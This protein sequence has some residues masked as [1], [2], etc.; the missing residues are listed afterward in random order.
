MCECVRVCA[1]V[2]GCGCMRV[3]I[4]ASSKTALRRMTDW[5]L[6]ISEHHRSE[7]HGPVAVQ[8]GEEGI[9]GVHDVACG[10]LTAFKGG[11]L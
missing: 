3:L 8:L 4:C 2:C 6:Q 11:V 5:C 7:H 1:S 9:F 10:N